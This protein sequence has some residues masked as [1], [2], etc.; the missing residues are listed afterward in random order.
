MAIL[1]CEKYKDRRE[2]QYMGTC[3][4]PYKYFIGNPNLTEPID[5]GDIVYLPCKDYYEDLCE[6]RRQMFKWVLDTYPEVEY[7]I[8][9]DDDVKF[10]F[11]KFKK[12]VDEVVEKKLSYAG[13]M[14]DFN[15]HYSEWHFGKCHDQNI[16]NTPYFLRKTSYCH[17]SVYFLNRDAAK[18]VIDY[19]AKSIFEDVECSY[20]L[21]EKGIN[22]TYISIENNSCFWD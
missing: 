8:K 16:N 19:S 10:I 17:G 18:I 4:Y 22:P 6:K 2:R 20:A 21:H 3:P 11:E 9:V 13:H 1:S 15:D 7:I 12:H 5:K 14:K